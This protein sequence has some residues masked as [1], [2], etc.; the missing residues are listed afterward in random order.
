[1]IT[2]LI[3]SINWVD[4]ALLVLFIR[5]IFVGVKNGFISEF[6]KSLGVVTAVFVSFHYYSFLGAWVAVKTN[7]TWDFWDFFMFAGLWFA[8]SVFFKYVRET[9]LILFNIETKHQGFD[10]YAAGIVAVGRGIRFAV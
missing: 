1:M 7:I 6:F 3:K 5:M 10:K 9:V 4:V 2:H 8:V